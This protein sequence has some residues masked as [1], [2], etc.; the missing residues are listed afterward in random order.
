MTGACKYV[1]RNQQ[2]YF[3]LYKVKDFCEMIFYHYNVKFS[4]SA[5]KIKHKIL[6]K[7]IMKKDPNLENCE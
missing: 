5:Q 1:G 2:T 6:E 3:A 4:S 7:S